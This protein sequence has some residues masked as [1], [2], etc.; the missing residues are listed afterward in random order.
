MPEYTI[1]AGPNGAGKSTFSS[2]LSEPGTLIFDADKVKARLWKEWPDLPVESIETMIT[3]Q[4]WNIEDE[5]IEKNSSLT[6]ESNLRDGFLVKRISFFK[7]KG[8]AANLIF[9]LLPSVKASMDRVDLRVDRKGHFVDQESIE[10]NFEHS[11]KMLKL[12]SGKFDNVIL[13][14]SSSEK[15]TNVPEQLLIIQNNKIHYLNSDIPGW[16]KP[17]IDEL[18]KNQ[19]PN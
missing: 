9:M 14:D 12:H 10:Y 3:T 6:V 4:Y 7:N 19:I 1:I 17:T 13:Y 8:C 18:I 5:A 15:K 11:L 16:A 2:G